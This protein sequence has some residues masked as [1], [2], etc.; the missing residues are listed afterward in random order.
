MDTDEYMKKILLFLLFLTPTISHAQGLSTEYALTLNNYYG[1]TDHS[2]PYNKLHKNNSIN[3]SLNLYTKASYRFDSDYELSL[4][5]YIMADSN[6]EVENYNQGKWGEEFFGILNSPLGEFSFGQMQNVAYNF[7]VG[8]P[9]VGSYRVNNT[10]LVNFIS[11]PNWYKKGSNTSYKTL[12]S[13]YLNTDG[14]S[15]KVNYT[16]PS[17]YGINLGISYIPDIYSQSGLVSK[18]AEYKNNDGYALGSYSFWDISGYELETS[19]GFAEYKDMDKEYSAGISIYRKGFTV[20]ASYRKTKSENNKYAINKNTLFDAYR[21]GEAY[22]IGISYSIGPITTGLSYFDSKSNIS[23]NRDKIISFS[24]TFEY[25]KNVS[26]SFTTAHI[27]STGEDKNVLNNNK[28]Y[29]F[30]FGVELSL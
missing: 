3:S 4:I 8:A 21:D 12:N 7:A 30:I 22:N 19:L 20:G 26:F 18:R 15:L 13:T 14:S 16:T 11:N 2:S 9:N 24:N 5:G 10:D 1:Y 25:N 17:F 23:K 29:A 28:G 6:K 27:D